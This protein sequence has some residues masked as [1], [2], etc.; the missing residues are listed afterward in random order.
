MMHLEFTSQDV[1]FTADMDNADKNVEQIKGPEY[2]VTKNS[3]ECFGNYV[4]NNH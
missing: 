3:F 4:H 2:K 1:K